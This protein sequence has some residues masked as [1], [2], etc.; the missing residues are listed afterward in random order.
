MMRIPNEC[1]LNRLQVYS[2]Y[3]ALRIVSRL[4]IFICTLC[5]I[6]DRHKVHFT[7]IIQSFYI[8]FPF[9]RDR[10]DTRYIAS[11]TTS[12]PCESDYVSVIVFKEI[13]SITLACWVNS[14]KFAAGRR[15]L[16][17]I[18]RSGGD[19]RIW[20][21]QYTKLQY[22][23]NVAVIDLPGHGQ[24]GG[25]G[26]QEVSSYVEWVRQFLDARAVSKT[27]LIGHSLGAAISLLFAIHYG[28][29]LSG[30]VA[31]GGGATMPV[32]EMILQGL[33]TDPASVI[34]LA[35]KFA[36]SKENRE[37]LSRTFTEGLS[38]VSPDVLYGDFLAC[39]RLDIR[40]RIS[41]ISIPKLIICGKDDKMTPPEY[42]QFLRD[43]I[44]GAQ[45]SLIENAGHMVMLENPATFNRS[46]KKFLESLL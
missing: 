46:L 14:G 42:S 13:H 16:V 39:D 33:K 43:A 1:R 30:I 23:F 26:E 6:C 19:H 44:P 41:K 38:R 40:D 27:V 5:G 17:F 11:R 12:L 20:I 8:T 29:I 3:S 9:F 32:N 34:A 31:V 36:I 22:E 2:F 35:A 15:S 10:R 37:R 25:N 7:D 45:L 18:H 28:E 24:S 21:K 4:S